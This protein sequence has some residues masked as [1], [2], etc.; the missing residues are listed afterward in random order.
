[1]AQVTDLLPEAM[2]KQEV[3]NVITYLLN[4]GAEINATDNYNQ[5]PLNYAAV[6]GNNEAITLLLKWPGIDPEV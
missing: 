2:I 4:H 1:M 3:E 5:T 6:K